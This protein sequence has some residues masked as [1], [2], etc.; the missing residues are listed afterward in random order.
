M[1]YKHMSHIYENPNLTFSEIKDIF[2]RASEGK[3]EGTEKTDGQNM[4]V[5]YSVVDKEAKAARNNSM[6]SG[7]YS[8]KGEGKVR[9]HAPGGVN[10]A[11]WAE[12]WADHPSKSVRAAF[13]EAF[14]IFENAARSLTPDEQE[15]V[16]GDGVNYLVF[17]N[18]EVQD[19]RNM[20]TIRYDKKTLTVHRVG[21]L[22]VD[23]E[24]GSVKDVDV[25]R[26]ALSLQNS[27]RTMQKSLE[28]TEFALEINA[29]RQLKALS[30][31]KPLKNAL[32]ALES[33]IDKEGI[34]DSQTVGDYTISR[35]L[36]VI[37]PYAEL[38]EDKEKMLLKKILGHKGLSINLVKKDLSPEQKEIVTKLYKDSRSLLNN[39]IRPLENVIH[40]FA[41]EMLKGLESAFV[42]DQ[43]EEIKRLRG[44]VA[45]K[46]KEIETSGDQ[47]K[48]D[49]LLRHFEKIKD[50]ENI[51]SAA[52]GFVFDYNGMTYKF[53]G[54]FAPI[55]QILGIGKYD[56]GPSTQPPVGESTL[57]LQEEPV[58]RVVALIPGK[59]KPPHRGHL[60]MVKHYAGIADVVKVLVSP[61]PAHS[62]GKAVEID[63]EDSIA[64][65][66]VY[67]R[68]SGL[69]NVEV[70]RS[71]K[72]SPVGASF[73]FV[74]NEEDRPEWA[75]PG[76]SIILG[77]S[78]KGGDESRFAGDVQ[79]YAREGVEVLDPMEYVFA[80]PEEAPFNASDVRNAL[81]AEEEIIRFIPDECIQAGSEPEIIS[82]LIDKPEKKTNQ[83]TSESLYSLVESVM[84]EKQLVNEASLNPAAFF[85]NLGA[86]GKGAI[87]KIKTN[88]EVGRKQE[89]A[90]ENAASLADIL[91][92]SQN[93]QNIRDNIKD[94]WGEMD[95]EA[96]KDMVD[97][98]NLEYDPKISPIILDAFIKR[99]FYR[100][101][102]KLKMAVMELTSYL[103]NDNFRR[104]VQT[105]P[106]T[107]SFKDVKMDEQVDQQDSKNDIYFIVEKICAEL[108]Y[109]KP[110]TKKDRK[111]VSRKIKFLKNKE[112]LT[113]DQ[114]VGK[115]LGM[116]S[117][118]SLEEEELEEMSSA[119]GTV[120]QPTGDVE[121]YA[122]P[123]K[124]RKRTTP[125][126]IRGEG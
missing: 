62:G 108:K 84:A 71:P 42:L 54:N 87:D 8:V 33:V 48:I 113:Q 112:G 9:Q 82:I 1:G 11:G 19:P 29:I 102:D 32:S 13:V 6:L 83:I 52:E 10:A 86:R 110:K 101:Q 73:D 7:M 88:I 75:Q 47:T 30:D 72:N 34:S 98:F 119:G 37:R 60:N 93:P 68:D 20:N 46:R 77:A 25:T 61:L 120:A 36:S 91:G 95:S 17:Y 118:D 103:F 24:D 123:V 116:F 55:N 106:L 96:K 99:T 58:G 80:P 126:L 70:M 69:V 27:L 89:E 23:M 64:I 41:V 56:R 40:D 90:H 26:N 111:K 85:R 81:E 107:T 104:Q 92:S 66:N 79:K 122:G 124:K 49:L 78:T 35:L 97:V 67:I 18:C 5:S 65:W 43:K 21:H 53:T 51:S 76:D 15:E 105:N 45:Q 63:A 100:E 109:K 50:L 38:P 16:F 3:L 59:F 14:E 94:M 57:M 4:L 22:Y 117:S 44:E 74:A 12:K 114:A 31:K 121:G 115:A 2:I 125:S 39:A 28:N